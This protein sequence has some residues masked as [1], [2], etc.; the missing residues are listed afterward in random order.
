MALRVL[1]VAPWG[2]RLGGAE[3][4]LWLTLKHCDRTRIEPAVVFLGPGPFAREVAGLGVPTE[5][6]GAGRLRDVPAT[7]GTVGRLAGVVRRRRPDVLLNWSAKA[8]IYGAPAA[9][10]AG[11]RVRTLWWQ[12]ATPDG[13]WV[14][15]LATL[16]PARAVGASSEAARAAQGA[17]RPRRPVFV[18]HP[19]VEWQRRPGSPTG[20]ETRR[21][22]GIPADAAV[23]GIVGRL[24]PFKCQ[25]R[26]LRALAELRRRGQDV[27]GLIVG[28]DAFDLAPAYLGELRALIRELGLEDRV[29]MTG[30]V[31]DATPYFDAMDVAV[32]ASVG[33]GFGIVLIEAMAAGVPVVAVASGGPREIVEDG[34]TGVLVAANGPALLAD[35][36]GGLLADPDRRARM[37]AAAT[38]ASRHRF[39]AEAM[40]ARITAELTELARA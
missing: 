17:L 28:G 4:M 1:I 14:D 40:A 2:D 35:A 32:S 13:H 11:G 29:T 23:A 22:L 38:R 33:E 20:A 19:G 9:V 5:T 26:F 31:A 12:H 27:H 8:H 36:V 6:I 21:R 3:E 16:L 37:S 7:I 10:A 15:R 18:V 39:S 25:D 34:V 30:Q 24:H